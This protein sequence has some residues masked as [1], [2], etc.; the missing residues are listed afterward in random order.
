MLVKLAQNPCQKSSLSSRHVEKKKSTY[1]IGI[2]TPTTTA[3]RN[4]GVAC[5]LR[6][7]LRL[8]WWCTVQQHNL[9]LY[10][11]RTW[12]RRRSMFVIHFQFVSIIRSV[13]WRPSSALCQVTYYISGQLNTTQVDDGDVGDDDD[14]DGPAVGGEPDASKSDSC[15]RQGVGVAADLTP[16]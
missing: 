6:Y 3:G 2:E 12:S 9:Q 8:R 4:P 14:G 10:C 7:T 11:D 15:C 16:I 5:T 1:H 13:N